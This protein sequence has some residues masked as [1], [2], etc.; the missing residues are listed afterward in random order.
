MNNEKLLTVDELAKEL[1]TPPSWVYSRTR[2]VGQNSIPVIRVGKYC[3]FRL[4]EV[5]EWLEKT[6]RDGENG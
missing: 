4:G 5:L 1:S 3:R 2:Q 6:N